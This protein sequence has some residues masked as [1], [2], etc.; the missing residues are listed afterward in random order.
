[1]AAAEIGRALRAARER[2][3]WSR[4]AL[5]YHANVSWAAIA[6][7]ESGRRSDVRLSSLAA[8]SG[9]LG[10]GIDHLAGTAGGRPPALLE[11]RALVYDSDD[12]LIEAVAP[13][14]IEG[15]ERG[16]DPLVVTTR[17]R[18]RRLR[19][20]VG[21][22]ADAVRFEDARTWYSSPLAALDRYRSYIDERIAAGCFW[23]R[24]VGE[25]VWPGRSPAGRRALTRYE[26]MINLTM[27]SAPATVICPYHRGSAPPSVVRQA[28]CTHPELVA[29]GGAVDSPCYEEPERFLIG[30]GAR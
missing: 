18:I 29:D 26:S 12:E 5:A 19:K 20:A 28:Y 24:I 8:L 2:R 14:V 9:A 10:V 30:N 6:Q 22:A 4:E 11:H 16:E 27:A 21:S 1:M 15:A 23:L 17:P 7:I 25:P 13:F 3:G